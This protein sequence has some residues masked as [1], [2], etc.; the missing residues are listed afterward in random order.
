MQYQ[1]KIQQLVT[2]AKSRVYRNFI[3]A[4]S[5]NEN[6][7]LNG[8]SNL[9]YF[10]T[11]CSYANFRTSTFRI[12]A[13]RYTLAP[14]EWM[15]PVRELMKIYRKKTEKGT[16]A[17]LERLQQSNHIRY[18]LL[19]HRRYVKFRINDW[20]KF[21]STI[22]ATAPCGF[23]CSPN[24]DRTSGFF[25]FPYKM[26]SEFIGKG[27]CSEMDILLDLWLNAIYNDERIAGSDVGPVVYYRS[28]LWGFSSRDCKEILDRFVE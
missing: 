18:E 19:H 6:I 24:T 13:M 26:V 14:G 12:D 21:N 1:L 25:F 2:Y 17:V 4:L 16:V 23:G 28:I 20:S 27:K 9:F 3:R 7:R 8:D 22:E 11:L 5:D 15:M 10:M